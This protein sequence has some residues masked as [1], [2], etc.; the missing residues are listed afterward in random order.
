MQSSIYE[1]RRYTLHPGR[2]DELIALFERHFIESQEQTGMELAGLFRDATRPDHFVWIRGFK[3]METRKEALTA[4]YG[5]ETW[6]RHRDAANAT[7]VDASDVLLLGPYSR[8]DDEPA[9]QPLRGPLFCLTYLFETRALLEDF[10]RTYEA[11]NAQSLAS[12]GA[13]ILAQFV[14]EPSENNF[15]RLPV[16]EGVHAFVALVDGAQ[17]ATAEASQPSEIAQLVPTRRS[18]IQVP[19][20]GERGDFD[21]LAGDWRVEHRKLRHRLKG[22]DAWDTI[23]GTARG[24]ALLDG[25]ISADEFSFENSAEKGGTFRHLDLAARQWSIYWTTSLSGALGSP[26]HGGFSGNRGEFYG[27]DVEDGVEVLVRYIW[28]EC[29]SDHPRWE[30]AFSANA[31]QTWETNWI[32]EFHRPEELS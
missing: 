13:R 17:R 8:K 3:D 11:R 23:G 4:F 31:G 12:Q 29:D 1:L 2:R 27:A 26:V 9:A 5:G 20:V 15:P 22:S 16:R 25:V 21:F 32:M 19:F 28:S 6:T 10:A 7:M 14:T 24:Y 18:K 30:Q